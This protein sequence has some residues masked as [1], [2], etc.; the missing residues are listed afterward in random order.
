MDGEPSRGS[1]D[2]LEDVPPSPSKR[3]LDVDFSFLGVFERI[4]AFEVRG[5][6]IALASTVC[7]CLAV[8]LAALSPLSMC[9][10]LLMVSFSALTVL[11]EVYFIAVGDVDHT[12]HHHVMATQQDIW[13]NTVGLVCRDGGRILRSLLTTLVPLI[14][15][16]FEG[17]C[18][19]FQV[20]VTEF[21]H[22]CS[23]ANLTE[24]DRAGHLVFSCHDGHIATHMQ[25]S[26]NTWQE[27]SY[28]SALL[29]DESLSRRRVHKLLHEARN[30]E[31]G[32]DN[33]GPQPKRSPKGEGGSSSD[34]GN[35]RRLGNDSL[36]AGL[37]ANPPRRLPT[38]GTR[39]YE[40]P[41]EETEGELDRVVAEPERMKGY[42]APLYTTPCRRTC[43]LGLDNYPAEN[44]IRPCCADIVPVA[45]AV[46]A[47]Q[48]ILPSTCAN[49]WKTQREL[50]PSGTCGIFA[51][52]LKD[53]WSWFTA[54]SRFGRSWGFNISH[55]HVIDMAH[56][57]EVAKLMH[58]ETLN[59]A[60]N[61]TS[62]DALPY[63]IAQPVESFFGTAYPMSFVTLTLLLIGLMDRC[64]N[65]TEY[66]WS[67]QK[68]AAHEPEPE[69]LGSDGEGK[70]P[71]VVSPS[72]RSRPMS[73]DP[74]VF[75][76][77]IGDDKIE[78]GEE[79][80]LFATAAGFIHHGTSHLHEEL[81]F[82]LRLPRRSP[83]AVPVDARLRTLVRLPS[84]VPAEAA[85]AS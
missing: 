64:M 11:M 80:S 31:H 63:V 5:W 14:L 39:R 40:L 60:P 69:E 66:S 17:V 1:G 76:R 27:D 34:G 55:F 70:G 74:P 79:L 38:M 46:S 12:D 51:L 15:G 2:E 50:F 47:G 13:K 78:H 32:N 48:P 28:Y 3:T 73:P 61:S 84:R 72:A 24:I 68:G 83:F 35:S 6:V 21:A 82:D 22:G 44:D 71:G 52:H 62:E 37:V 67:V 29:A 16:T 49:F 19:L 30:A 77:K 33:V 59:L 18:F 26:V 56:A 54:P 65:L 41:L 4:I 45:W 58:N 81:Q 25:V 20:Q 8:L 85:A 43:T 23:V 75:T 42:L 10:T 36:L 57:V 53:K 7:Y 9:A